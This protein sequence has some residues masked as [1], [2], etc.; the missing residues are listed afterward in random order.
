MEAAEPRHVRLEGI[1]E[2]IEAIDTVSGMASRTIRVFGHSLEG[3]G[4][5]SVK[6]HEV[7]QRFLLASRNNRLYIVLHDV[8]HVMLDCPRLMILLRQFSH[9]VAIHQTQAQAQGVYDPFVVADGQHY[10]RRFHYEDSRGLLALNDPQGAETL[11]HRFAELWEASFSAV[12]ATT[13]GL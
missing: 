4:F 8:N 1:N 13:T 10:V 5:N 11:N 12:S 7:L 6:R 2:Y 3:M 9:A